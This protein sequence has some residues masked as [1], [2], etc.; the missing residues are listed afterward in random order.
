MKLAFIC[1]NEQS[2]FAD[3]SCHVVC[4]LMLLKAINFSPLPSYEEL[5]KFFNLSDSNNLFPEIAT[6]DILRFIV[7]NNLNFRILFRKEDW[8]EALQ[9]API[10]AAMYGGTR[11]WG[12]GGHMII[13]TH[14][15]DGLFTYLDPWFSA[16]TGRH[17]KTISMEEFYQYY[18]G[19]ACQ[20][21]P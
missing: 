10:M 2:I 21:F 12:Q 11:F 9:K 6:A 14:L 13:L 4:L 17:I 8:E 19:F 1:Q 7:K 5:C 16:S 15:K 3:D 20:L 18:G